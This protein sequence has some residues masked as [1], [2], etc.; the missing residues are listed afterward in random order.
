MSNYGFS[1][2]DY[3]GYFVSYSIKQIGKEFDLLRISSDYIIN[4][5]LKSRP[6]STEA[7]KKQL[8]Q[9]RYYLSMLG[10][11]IYS[12]T[13]ISSENRLVRLSNTDKIIDS[14]L[15]AVNKVS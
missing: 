8:I 10:K 13:Y 1:Y 3:D 14:F 12:Y 7:I 4:I 11:T 6:V 15:S 9:N 2:K 5:E